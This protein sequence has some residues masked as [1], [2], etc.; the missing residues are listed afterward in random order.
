MSMGDHVE[1][2]T[3]T[4]EQ[5]GASIAVIADLIAIAVMVLL[6]FR[7]HR[8][9]DLVLAFV[10]VNVGVLVVTI[11]LANAP[12]AAGLGLGLFGIL[13]IIRLR[14]DALTHEEIA[15]YFTALALGLLAGL[16]P[17]PL[18][19]VAALSALLVSLVAVADSPR[20]LARVRRQVVVLDRAVAEE[21][22]LKTELESMLGG[23]VKHIVVQKIDF[24]LDLTVVDVRFEA[25]RPSP[26]GEVVRSHEHG[27]VVA[28]AAKRP[29]AQPSAVQPVR[30]R[31]GA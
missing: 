26:P 19:F 20:L 22:T 7:R 2:N 24:V 17:G 4:N 9:R 10:A 23:T 3:V 18:W 27:P 25:P 14:S 8:R 6:Y 1:R 21:V 15:Y 5:L 29:W 30:T 31:N 11:A 28:K 13:S 16:H 12:S